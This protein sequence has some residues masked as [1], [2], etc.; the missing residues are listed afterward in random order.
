[1]SWSEAVQVGLE[2]DRCGVRLS[3]AEVRGAVVRALKDDPIT[4]PAWVA[5][6]GDPRAIAE[7]SRALDAHQPHRDCAVL[8][9]LEVLGLGTA[10]D[11]LGGGVVESQ[12][13]KIAE[14]AA[15]QD[16]EW[17]DDG[18]AA[19]A[20]LADVT[21]LARRTAPTR[22]GPRLGQNDPCHCG[23]GKKYKACHL[24]L[25]RAAPTGTLH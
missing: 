7:L 22:R 18:D 17:G 6:Y 15:R 19:R 10:I 16:G 1:M 8:D 13:R 20:M 24:D 3:D 4:G 5:T 2:L 11:M 23:S 14:Y 12:C 21:P 9:Y 25:D